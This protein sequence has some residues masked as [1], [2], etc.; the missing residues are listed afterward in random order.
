MN[1]LMFVCPIAVGNFLRSLIV[2]LRVMF[3]NRTLSKLLFLFFLLFP[4]TLWATWP[5]Y[6]DLG[7]EKRFLGPLVS[8]DEENQEKHLVIRPFFF[9][10]DSEEGGVYNYLFPFGKVT[11]EKSY[12]IPIYLSRRS[13]TESDASFLL[14]FGGRS[15][16]GRYGGFFP[17]YGKLYDRFAKDE[18]GFCLWPFYSYT[19][20][21][22]ATKRNVLWP[23]SLFMEAPT[24]DSR[25]GRHMENMNGLAYENSSFSSGLFFSRTKK[26]L[27]PMNR[28]IP[29]LPCLSTLGPHH[30][31]QNIGLS[32]GPFLPTRKTARKKSGTC[33]GPFIPKLLVKKQR[34][35]AFSLLFP[36]RKAEMIKVFIFSGLSTRNRSGM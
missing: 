5:L 28:S 21:E 20:D 30:A 25:L 19:H 27:I 33:P 24:R 35:T 34:D 32:Y 14:F 16:K 26:T 3:L 11:P 7:G 6:W 18:M 2:C 23:F 1:I 8:Y 36:K 29:F 15:P 10:Y 9:S 31:Q 22:G 17:F 12:F 4:S 13:E